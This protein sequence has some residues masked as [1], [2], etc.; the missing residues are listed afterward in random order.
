MSG[1]EIN[2]DG[3]VGPTHNYGGLSLG[4]I[5]SMGSGGDVS[6]PK[7]AALQGLAKMKTMVSL[8]LPQ[9][10]LP[11]HERPF[12]P[13][14]R[15]WGFLGSDRDVVAKAATDAPILLRNASSASAMWTANAATVSPSPDT[16][17]GRL[18]FTP[19]N[20]S[21]MLHR[22]IEA[23]FTARVLAT[24]FSDGALFAHHAP[25]PG[26]GGM[27]DEG[28]ANHGRLCDAHGSS[29]V[30]LF[31]YGKSV[32][33]NLDGW[34][35]W[36]RQAEEAS[37][38]IIRTHGVAQNAVLLRQSREAVE[39]GAFHND[40]VA[41]AN[42]PVLLY[43]ERAF[44]DPA[45]PFDRVRALSEARGFDPVF[46]S[47]AESDVPLGDAI[48]SYLFNS[49]LVTLPSGEMAL[50]LPGEAERN[51]RAKAWVDGVIAGNAPITAAHYLDLHQSMKNGGGPACLRLRVAVTETEQQAIHQ[52]F[53]LDDEKIATLEAWV[54]RYYRDR[55][56]SAELADPDLLI[57]TREAL[58]GLTTQLGMGSLYDFQ[59]EP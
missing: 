13:A 37:A 41:V 21:S 30:E 10:F 7:A 3:L 8:G 53:L 40:V 44:A 25:V 28:A 14:L 36:P 57:E 11:P 51:D 32:F 5:A 2:F 38:A 43:H 20:L 23:P 27:G 35:F 46:L 54:D 12:V 18:H 47:V 31:V 52:G 17:D 59:R 45:E 42:G 9:G 49:Q 16:T 50:I 24:A 26:G 19:A 29:G 6:N 4:N 48:S 22:S 1:L 56:S 55:M 34:R 39:A 15:R 33:D 58:D